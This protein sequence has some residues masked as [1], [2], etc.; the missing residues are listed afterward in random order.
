MVRTRYVRT[1]EGAKWY[2]VPVGSPIPK[3]VG[4]KRTARAVLDRL[5]EQMSL[6]GKDQATLTAPKALKAPK[7]KARLTD[8]A[9][10]AATPSGATPMTAEMQHGTVN[11]QGVGSTPAV[12]SGGL[13]VG[14]LAIWNGGSTSRVT[15]VGPANRRRPDGMQRITFDNG[16]T[17]DYRRTTLVAITERG[18]APER[19]IS[20]EERAK[21]RPQAPAAPVSEPTPTSGPQ[22]VES[23]SLQIGDLIEQNGMRLRV[24]SN[25]PAAGG[26]V[27]R[28][29][30]EF[31]IEGGSRFSN[32]ADINTTYTERARLHREWNV[33]ERG[34]EASVA[35]TGPPMNAG[36]AD[37]LRVGDV[38]RMGGEMFTLIGKT[39]NQ[40]QSRSMTAMDTDGRVRDLPYISDDSTF[41]TTADLDARR[42]EASSGP[43]PWTPRPGDDTVATLVTALEVGDV[44]HM[45]SAN[46][47]TA[48]MQVETVEFFPTIAQTDVRLR[49]LDTGVTQLYEFE[50]REEL[51]KFTQPE[52][53]V[54]EAPTVVVPSAALDSVNDV[55]GDGLH[56]GIT[57]F[58]SEL[59]APQGINDLPA[60]ADLFA[61][62]QDDAFKLLKDS[63]DG[64]YGALKFRLTDV[65]KNGSV[66]S[67]DG[68]IY[69]PAGRKIGRVSR[70]IS[71][72]FDGRT[73][74]HNDLMQ[75]QK[76]WRGQGFAS[77]FY[78]AT[79]SW[80]RRA[81]VDYIDIH[82]ALEDGAYTWAKAGFTWDPSMNDANSWHI[83]AIRNSMK[84]HASVLPQHDRER[85][86]DLAARMELPDASNWP[87]PRTIAMFTDSAGNDLGRS[88]LHHQEWM[89][90]KPL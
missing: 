52:N 88:I 65:T 71:K 72:Q 85:L 12:R 68:H 22:N 48:P 89:G 78:G 4:P 19:Y 2:G 17:R 53:T 34:G 32:P 77:N 74:V 75:I 27:E 87:H 21:M 24:M 43:T 15:G 57:S 51:D 14:D 59:T 26:R 38:F 3:K 44:L 1:P 28:R 83:K 81:G 29:A 90:I 47:R 58:G 55:R 61:M 45:P 33:T 31:R 54:F 46:G 7:A 41:E 60:M 82:A 84:V 73:K 5:G 63:L 11:I 70:T 37:E 69:N 6:F 10:R 50:D 8:T 86:M 80:Y 35:P 36:R 56:P 9:P 20:E 62:T 66:V 64:E 40:N 16:A 79:E 18:P 30:I 25:E 39:G 13:R 49:N 23:G 42:N 67:F 76:P